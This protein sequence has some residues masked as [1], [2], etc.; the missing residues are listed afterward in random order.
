MTTARSHTSV[1]RALALG[2]GLAGL[3][4][5]CSSATEEGIEQL[6]ES[7]SGGDVEID[8]D[9]GG[10]SFE[11]DEGS[12]SVDE[13]GNFIIE[14]ADGEVVTGQ[15][16]DGSFTLEDEDGVAEF[17]VDE[18]DGDVSVQTE[19]GSFEF[20]EGSEIP[21][22]WPSEVPVP[23]GLTITS[24]AFIGDG[25]T[26]QSTVTGDVAGSPVEYA[27]AYGALLVAE[28]FEETGV[29]RS[30]DDI[31]STYMSDAY[32]VSIN[33]LGSTGE[34]IVTIGVFNN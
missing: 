24:S 8:L 6:I 27:E 13:D 15:A 11:S 28:G 1:R 20:N 16:G 31:T 22:E 18:E 10:F 14:G 32:T 17:G 19:D 23:E 25:T 29:F 4:A 2:V 30:G 21:D 7:Q 12:M 5:A 26:G 33:G 3:T 9:D 34:S